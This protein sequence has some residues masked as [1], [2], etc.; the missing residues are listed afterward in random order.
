M[1]F[2]GNEDSFVKVLNQNINEGLNLVKKKSSPKF[3]TGKDAHEFVRFM[4][5]GWGQSPY[6][7]KDIDDKF[8]YFP[9]T[10]HNGEITWTAF[11]NR[12]YDLFMETFPT[13][14]QAKE[15]ALGKFDVFDQ[16]P[17]CDGR[18][19]ER[20]DNT[21]YRLNEGLNLVKKKHLDYRYYEVRICPD[22]WNENDECI[23]GWDFI[24]FKY[25]KREIDELYAGSSDPNSED[26][27]VLL[28]YALSRG[29]IQKYHIDMA[30]EVLEI[31]KEEYYS[32][33]NDNDYDLN[34]GL[35]LVKK[36]KSSISTE[37][38]IVYPEG[39]IHVVPYNI[40]MDLKNDN[41]ISWDDEFTEETP[42]GQWAISEENEWIL[43]YFGEH[44]K[45]PPKYSDDTTY[46][47]EHDMVNV[48]E[49]VEDDNWQ[50]EFTGTV[51]GFS[52]PYVLVEDGDNDIFDVD[53]YR[54]VKDE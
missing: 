53:P 24:Y 5:D 39:S 8:G 51:V 19:C 46:I 43:L 26:G 31:P 33:S 42:E 48:P 47:K 28:H 30:S 16:C 13:E 20:C 25:P 52:G 34:E 49:P 6:G 37:P 38:V 27:S 14:H 45:L 18:G 22:G 12:N 40:I 10:K 1:K 36:K 41:I 15:W 23:G 4:F 35:N 44:S 32:Q 54:L 9:E 11:D 29:L 3:L 21:G 2:G 7:E 50:H 17:N